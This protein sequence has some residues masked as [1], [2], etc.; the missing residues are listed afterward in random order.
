MYYIH[1]LSHV[2][3]R[4][5]QNRFILLKTKSRN[6]WDDISSRKLLARREWWVDILKI[7]GENEKCSLY[8]YV[9]RNSN[10]SWTRD[11]TNIH[12]MRMFQRKLV[13]LKILSQWNI[14]NSNVSWKIWQHCIWLFFLYSSIWYAL[15]YIL[16]IH[17]YCSNKFFYWDEVDQ[18]K[19]SIQFIF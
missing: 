12:W 8:K 13:H 17:Y 9:K 2:F 14:E 10:R 11:L 16:T 18:K 6:I 7:K 3:F 15:K 5:F 1:D 4:K 19:I